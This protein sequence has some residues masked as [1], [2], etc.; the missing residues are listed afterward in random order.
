[1]S[2]NIFGLSNYDINLVGHAFSLKRILNCRPVYYVI[3]QRCQP[4]TKSGH[5]FILILSSI[6]KSLLSY[7]HTTIDMCTCSMK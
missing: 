2:K 3:F 5:L 1:M 7:T 6:N 4:Y